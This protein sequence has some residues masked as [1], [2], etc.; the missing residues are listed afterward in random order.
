MLLSGACGGG[1]DDVDGGR[2]G[3]GMIEEEACQCWA[4]LGGEIPIVNE[5]HVGGRGQYKLLELGGVR[6]AGRGL[7]QRGVYSDRDCGTASREAQELGTCG[8][9]E[10][11]NFMIR[12]WDPAWEMIAM[13][14]SGGF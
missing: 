12:R 10:A 2:G 4:G 11:Q 14:G 1:A 6:R 8:G 9:L 5:G 3:G 7:A 13:R